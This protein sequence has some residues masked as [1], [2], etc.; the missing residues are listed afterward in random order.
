[1]QIEILPKAFATIRND[2]VRERLMSF[3][4]FRSLFEV[5]QERTGTYY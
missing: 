5:K 2:S 3:P 4:S 1:M